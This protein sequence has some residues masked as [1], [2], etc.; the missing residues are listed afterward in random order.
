MS[1]TDPAVAN[2]ASASALGWT[3]LAFGCSGHG[4]ELVRAVRAAQLRL[5]FRPTGIV[6]GALLRMVRLDLAAR[7]AVE[8]APG[9]NRQ[10]AWA[11]SWARQT[12]QSR[13]LTSR[14]ERLGD[15]GGAF[16]VVPYGPLPPATV[17]LLRACSGR[18]E[19]VVT[20]LAHATLDTAEAVLGNRYRWLTYSDPVVAQLSHDHLARARGLGVEGLVLDYATAVEAPTWTRQ[21]V[22]QA[23]RY[24]AYVGIMADL[25]RPPFNADRVVPGQPAIYRGVQASVDFVI[26]TTATPIGVA[27][28]SRVAR[29]MDRGLPRSTIWPL[30][31]SSGETVSTSYG[32][33]ARACANNH[34]RAIGYMLTGNAARDLT[35]TALHEAPAISVDL[36]HHRGSTSEQSELRIRAA[37]RARRA[38]RDR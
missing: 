28:E 15:L 20:S 18:F 19:F 32:R 25:L 11:R 38:A 14:T 12:R 30:Y 13:T 5:G 21:H 37:G 6:D 33:F 3:P 16:L 17:E 35:V 8:A 29:A 4:P 34:S 7:Q 27:I 22:A 23:R 9:H 1:R 24:F 36:H 31:V 26:A 2:L 10:D